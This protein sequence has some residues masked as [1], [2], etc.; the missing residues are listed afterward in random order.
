MKLLFRISIILI[1]LAASCSKEDF[2]P[3]Y[4]YENGVIIKLPRLWSRLLNENQYNIKGYIDIQATYK[5]NIL[6][7]SKGVEGRESLT[8]LNSNSG[9]VVWEWNDIFENSPDNNLNI[10]DFYCNNNLFT[11]VI[12]GRNYCVNLDNGTTHWKI[13][14]DITFHSRISGHSNSFFAL[15]WTKLYPQYEILVGFSGNVLT[16]EIEEFL[17]PDFSFDYT[18]SGRCCDVTEMQP[19]LKDGTL[20]LVVIYQE[21]TD[22]EIWNFQS[23]MG[24]YNLETEEWVYDRKIMNE[25]I[26]NGVSLSP[27]SIYNDKLYAN[28]G[29]EIVCHDIETG[30]QIWSRAFQNDF[31]FSGFI[32]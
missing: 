24:L 9:N 22:S 2:P 12:G 20:H 13:Y 6:V 26:L 23:F 18:N 28:I 8:L 30:E 29:Y 32:I 1:L 27:P 19:Y 4:V 10:A 14:R 31:L 11:W 5:N 7:I 15:G 21:L 17:I 16:G 3:D 25:P